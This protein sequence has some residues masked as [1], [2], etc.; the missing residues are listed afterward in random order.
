MTTPDLEV[1]ANPTASPVSV[2]D[3]TEDAPALTNFVN[4]AMEAIGT[5]V[6][7]EYQRKANDEAQA[8]TDF[9]SGNVQ[10][11]SRYY[12][13]KIENLQGAET[14]ATDFSGRM[15]E[16]LGNARSHDQ[17]WYDTQKAKL[18]QQYFN[19]PSRHFREG[20]AKQAKHL[21]AQF[22][23]QQQ[24]AKI[25]YIKD[26]RATGLRAKFV[27]DVQAAIASGMDG[28]E[29]D[30]FIRE[31]ASGEAEN[32]GEWLSKPEAMTHMMQ[33]L[34]LYG[35]ESGGKPELF[36]FAFLKDADGIAPAD[37][38][39]LAEQVEQYRSLQLSLRQRIADKAEAERN[40]AEEAL[41]AAIVKDAY[42][43]N[44]TG[45][46]VAMAESANALTQVRN[47]KAMS[48]GTW[49]ALMN[50]QQ[51]IYAIG[52]DRTY[53]LVLP[54]EPKEPV[55]LDWPTYMKA[56]EVLKTPG[57]DRATRLEAFNM[58][59]D[60]G[61]SEGQKTKWADWFVSETTK[62]ADSAWAAAKPPKELE[63]TIDNALKAAI[64]QMKGGGGAVE[65]SPSGFLMTSGKSPQDLKYAQVKATLDVTG[66]Q[67][68]RKIVAP[69]LAKGNIPTAQ[70]I[71][72]IVQSIANEACNEV[73]VPTLKLFTT[74]SEKTKWQDA[75]SRVNRMI[76]EVRAQAAP[77]AAS[78][79]EPSQTP[80]QESAD[81]PDN[82]GVMPMPDK[83]EINR[84]R[85]PKN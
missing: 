68:V 12:Q 79:M 15:R 22:D 19:N 16:I 54:K 57:V 76:D 17:E 56:Q 62:E 53:G 58:L 80:V 2:N 14:A 36:N 45:D 51:K 8:E 29:L 55:E 67:Q 25:K 41:V 23:Q 13:W 59:M 32:Y 33:A 9:Y 1:R 37:N 11:K 42:D 70:A 85:P 46:P 18:I 73:G 81:F 39:A 35:M 47:L 66:L 38:A 26:N 7:A 43:A 64:S 82:L 69:M 65:L 44:R 20:F 4:A 84:K 3:G 50:T 78:T 10:N 27:G 63:V 24:E 49:N 74:T 30:T 60:S 75:D 31:A 6:K 48:P 52:R 5:G 34:H 40:K 72:E 83:D 28:D 77:A 21:E 61:L 71:Q